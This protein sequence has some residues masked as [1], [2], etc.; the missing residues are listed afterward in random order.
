MCPIPPRTTIILLILKHSGEYGFASVSHLLA[1]FEDLLGCSCT[2]G[3]RRV[4]TVRHYS[5]LVTRAWSILLD[6]NI[7]LIELPKLALASLISTREIEICQARYHGSYILNILSL[8]K[9]IIESMGHLSLHYD[10]TSALDW[11][12]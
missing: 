7:Y 9:K 8:V 12:P 2:L 10:I 6:C 1:A 4:S 3:N 5:R 11:A